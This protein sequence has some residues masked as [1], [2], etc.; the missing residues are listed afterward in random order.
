MSSV[1]SHKIASLELGR[2]I[3]MFAIVLLHSHVLHNAPMV[4]EAP[5]FG[6]II[7]QLMRFAVPFFFILSGY[8]V[9]PKL[10]QAPLK[11]LQRYSVPL[12]KV[13][14]IWSIICLLM[15]FNWQVLIE[16]GYLAER[17]GYWDW[18][19]KNPLN[20]LMEGGLIHLW[21]I[22]GLILAV[23][24]IAV[25]VRFKLT[26]WLPAVALLLYLYG[27]AG[28]SY[29][30]LTEIWTPF[31]TRN[32]PFFSTLMVWIG[33]AVRTRALH[34]SSKQAAVLALAGMAIHF[35]E[36]IWLSGHDVLFNSHDFLLGTPLWGLGVFM[37][38][39]NRPQLGEHPVVYS[40]GDKV[41]GIYVAHMPFLII[42][43]NLADSF[44][45]QNYAKDLCMVLGTTL[46]TLLFIA[47]TTRSPAR[48]LLYR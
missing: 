38:L 19:M 16:Q 12:F 40:L 9:A 48:K 10:Q 36:A 46:T 47:L 14:V 3:S 27:V 5:W 2:L 7:D 17:T 39:L 33:F 22:P 32:G 44:G 11:T 30:T 23:A 6:Y 21:F 4:N 13:W 1:H 25:C 37:L 20:T 18:L 43:Y 31:L 26:S 45:L 41:L 24:I 35:A 34:I 28:G 15:P 42:V 8:L 29:G